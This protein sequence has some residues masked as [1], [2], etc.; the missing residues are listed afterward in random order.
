LIGH[1]VIPTDD[2]FVKFLID[3][4]IIIIGGHGCALE[5]LQDQL[6]KNKM[7]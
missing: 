1:S 4:I 7:D 5:I 2:P 6:E 3:D